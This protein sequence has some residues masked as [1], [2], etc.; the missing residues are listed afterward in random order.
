MERR[1]NE[2][3]S[4]LGDEE[5]GSAIRRWNVAKLPGKASENLDGGSSAYRDFGRWGAMQTIRVN[6]A[7]DPAVTGIVYY[8]FLAEVSLTMMPLYQRMIL[9]EPKR[10]AEIM[11]KIFYFHKQIRVRFST[12]SWFL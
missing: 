5:F 1:G 11:R 2:D 10:L 7:A 9:S 8:L 4:Q 12:I 6:P 3:G